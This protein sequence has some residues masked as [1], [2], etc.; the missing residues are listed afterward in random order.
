MAKDM[1]Q[2]ENVLR[3]Y[4]QYFKD[5]EKKIRNAESMALTSKP[6]ADIEASAPKN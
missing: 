4:R 5:E 1:L 3:K 6:S 2:Y